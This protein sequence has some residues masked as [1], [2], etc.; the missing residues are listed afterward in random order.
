MKLMRYVVIHVESVNVVGVYPASTKKEAR[1]IREELESR[2]NFSFREAEAV[3]IWNIRTN[4]Q[5]P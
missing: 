1:K 3:W 4:E 5:D 2:Q